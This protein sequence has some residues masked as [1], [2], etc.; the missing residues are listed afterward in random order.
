MPATSTQSGVLDRTTELDLAP[1]R[2]R[3]TQLQGIARAFADRVREGLQAHGQEIRCLPTYLPTAPPIDTHSAPLHGAATDAYVLDL[4]G[5]NLRAA[6][7]GLENGRLCLRAG[8]VE[9][10][11]PWRAGQAIDAN[12][13]FAAHQRTL[14]S[15]GYADEAGKELPLGYCFSYPAESMPDGDAR[16]IKWTKEID[17]P[18]LVGEPIGRRLLQFFRNRSGVS[19]SRVVV[20]NDTVASLLSGLEKPGYDAYIGLVAG[21][22]FNIAALFERHGVAKLPPEDELGR[23]AVNLECGNFTPPWLTVWDDALDQQSLDR[24]RQRLEKSISGGYL[25]TLAEIV[26]GETGLPN[27]ATLAR[28]LSTPWS[29]PQ[30]RVATAEA[31]FL[32]SA[33]LVAAALAGLGL[34]LTEQRSIRSVRISAEG[35]LFWGQVGDRQLFAETTLA[36]LGRLQKSL[37]L[38]ALDIDCVRQEHANLFGAAMAVLRPEALQRT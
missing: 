12:T 31:I 20:V 8:P 30:D 4:G 23:L 11:M 17:I 25:G 15:L 16:L 37:G 27:A 14:E 32:R 9:R 38:G 10:S 34:V 6:V 7:V 28:V 21:T 26:L 18:E 5:S 1:L 3:A 29:H 13:F 33:K 35:G 19:C 2:L 24:G 36:T 22:G